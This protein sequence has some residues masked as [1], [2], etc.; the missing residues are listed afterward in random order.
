MIVLQNLFERFLASLKDFP[1]TDLTVHATLL[2]DLSGSRLFK[3]C[4]KLQAKK[5]LSIGH[6]CLGILDQ[7]PKMNHVSLYLFSSVFSVVSTCADLD[8]VFNYFV[9]AIIKSNSKFSTLQL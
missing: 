7:L 9:D 4:S 1:K 6:D 3:K 8:L 5:C 2:S